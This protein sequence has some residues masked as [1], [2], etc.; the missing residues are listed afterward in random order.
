MPWFPEEAALAH[1]S[2]ASDANLWASAHMPGTSRISA[3]QAALPASRLKMFMQSMAILSQVT[4]LG[5][6]TE[7][8]VK[9]A[10]LTRTGHSGC[11]SSISA[12]ID[13][14]T[15]AG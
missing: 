14:S 4:H 1:S 8:A 6:L 5:S 12:S 9:A 7:S 13:G 3:A 11:L 15:L 10:A 2:A